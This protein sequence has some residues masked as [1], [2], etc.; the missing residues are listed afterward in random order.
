MTEQVVRLGEVRSNARFIGIL[1]HGH[2]DMRA[3][4]PNLLQ[5]WMERSPLEIGRAHP[6]CEGPRGDVHVLVD[7]AP[8]STRQNPEADPREDVRVVPLTG[9]EDATPSS[10]VTGSNG[11]PLVNIARPPVQ[12]YASLAVHSALKVGLL[13]AQMMGLSFSSA[14]LEHT[15]R[16]KLL[17]WAET[18]INTLADT[19]STAH[20]RSG[21]SI[22][23]L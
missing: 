6:S 5:R 22:D 21:H 14:I 1:G 19:T 8:R 13:R 2:G 10:R 7:I 12:E 4:V 15:P 23:T 11:E 17:G 20:L 9:S 16:S 3:D 18:P